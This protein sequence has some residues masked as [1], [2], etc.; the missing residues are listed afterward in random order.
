MLTERSA[1]DHLLLVNL[2]NSTHF[3]FVLMTSAKWEQGFITAAA[4]SWA[5]ELRAAN[6]TSR[7]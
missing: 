2:V 7:N 4:A 1:R 6:V 5:V 3:H